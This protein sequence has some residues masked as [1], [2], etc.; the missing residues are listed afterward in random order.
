MNP[1]PKYPPIFTR[2]IF[3]SDYYDVFPRVYMIAVVNIGIGFLCDIDADARFT[4]NQ[5]DT[6]LKVDVLLCTTVI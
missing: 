5:I 2:A 3:G 4:R 1:K 6:I